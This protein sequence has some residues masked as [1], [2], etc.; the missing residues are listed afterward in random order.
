M[1]N[2]ILYWAKKGVSFIQSP[3]AMLLRS[4]GVISD[5]YIRLDQPWLQD[6]GIKTVL[7]IGGN[8]GRFSKTM[9]HLFPNAQIISFEPLPS[10]H[11][12]MVKLMD[13]YKNF[14]SYNIGLGDE[15]GEL[16]MEE[17][18]HNPSS[19]LLPMGDLHKDAFPFAEGGVKKKVEVR[20]L[21]D[22]QAELNL[23]YPMLIKVDVQGF[24]DKVVKGGLEVFSKAKVL[25]LELSFQELY[26]GQPFF[27]DI[28]KMLIPMGFKFYGSMGLMKHPKTGL[29]LDADCLFIN[30][31][32]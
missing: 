19:S 9:E 12:Q 30:E 8:V 23:Q 20:R 3:H 25:V 26:E 15:L 21:D 13:G 16:E 11:A 7:D 24:E 31:K 4:K 27:D 32:I 14:K 29:P 2:K 28:Y 18:N 10:C 5:F 22:M 1:K 17:S 6:L